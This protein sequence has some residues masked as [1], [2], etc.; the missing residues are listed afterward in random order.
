MPLH[1]KQVVAHCAAANARLLEELG[2]QV[3]LHLGRQ[4]ARESH[5]S[6]MHMRPAR[7]VENGACASS[8]IVHNFHELWALPARVGRTLEGVGV[9]LRRCRGHAAALARHEKA[10]AAAFQR[11]QRRQ[12]THV[13]VLP[14][15]WRRLRRVESHL[16][17]DRP[18]GLALLVVWP[19]RQLEDFLRGGE[20][21]GVALQRR[22]RFR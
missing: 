2:V 17:D 13:A 21:G 16:V 1:L 22:R 20:G 7:R 5:L 3:E 9:T 19:A 6:L 18:L 15:N 4:P 14:R 10:S 8:V 12:R 11:R